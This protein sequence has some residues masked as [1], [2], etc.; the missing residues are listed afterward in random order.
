MTFQKQQQLHFFLL[1]PEVIFVFLRSISIAL[2]CRKPKS[3]ERMK[4]KNQ[5]KRLSTPPAP[6][7]PDKKQLPLNI[8]GCNS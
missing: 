5:T 6:V 1:S 4:T 8:G 2:K 7:N 3:T